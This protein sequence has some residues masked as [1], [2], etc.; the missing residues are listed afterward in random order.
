M[1]NG[2]DPVLCPCL[3]GSNPYTFSST[4]V[5]TH[6]ASAANI[7][8]D[9]PESFWA[10]LGLIN[11][12]AGQMTAAGSNLC[13]EGDGVCCDATVDPGAGTYVIDPSIGDEDTRDPWRSQGSV[14]Y[15]GA[16]AVNGAGHHVSLTS[17][18]CSAVDSHAEPGAPAETAEHGNLHVCVGC[19]Q[20]QT[21]DDLL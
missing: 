7:T 13:A 3:G 16:P 6:D 14:N 20:P 9:L 1:D 15:P 18:Q 17:D 4:V 2:W 19:L 8:V 21:C 12:G 11:K 5:S 10:S